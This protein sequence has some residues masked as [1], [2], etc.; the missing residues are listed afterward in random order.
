MYF[1]I[2]AF[3]CFFYT[4]LGHIVAQHKLWIN[5]QH[6][7][8]ALQVSPVLLLQA[9]T[10]VFCPVIKTLSIGKLISQCLVAV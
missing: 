8:A 4:G 7:F 10:I 6:L 9:T 5:T 3:L 1:A 2:I